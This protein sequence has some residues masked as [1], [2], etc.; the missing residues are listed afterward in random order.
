MSEL[1]ELVRDPVIAGLCQ[2]SISRVP[3]GWPAE[4]IWEGGCVH[5]HVTT[6]IGICAEHRELADRPF[7]CVSCEPDHKCMV[8]LREAAA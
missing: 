7:A 8:Q 2:V 6:E 3:C 1:R 4:G 5:E